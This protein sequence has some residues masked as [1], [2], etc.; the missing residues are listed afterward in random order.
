MSEQNPRDGLLRSL[1]QIRATAR[2]L[3]NE[4]IELHNTVRFD[5]RSKATRERTRRL[6][7]QMEQLS[8]ALRQFKEHCEGEQDDQGSA[9]DPAA[10]ATPP[11]S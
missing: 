8:A 3:E 5:Y 1:D 2:K 6:E 10:S 11:S 9:Q 7:G 4:L